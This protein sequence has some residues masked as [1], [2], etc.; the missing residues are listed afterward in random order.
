MRLYFS[1]PIAARSSATTRGKYRQRHIPSADESSLMT[2][3][4]CHAIL[5][6]AI[7]EAHASAFDEAVLEYIVSI[8][9]DSSSFEDEVELSEVECERFAATF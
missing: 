7:G 2:E 5:L 8:I 6:A 1:Q 9:S 4:D 3:E